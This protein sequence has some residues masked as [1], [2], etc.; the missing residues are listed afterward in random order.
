MG[1]ISMPTSSEHHAPSISKYHVSRPACISIHVPLMLLLLPM[2]V[3][4][5]TAGGG[6]TAHCP[7]CQIEPDFPPN[8][9]ILAA[10]AAARVARL[11][12][13]L[14]PSWQTHCPPRARVPHHWCCSEDQQ[15]HTRIRFTVLSFAGV[16]LFITACRVQF[17]VKTLNWLIRI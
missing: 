2:C 6:D 4:M 17:A 3:I 7:G 1:N 13:K 11:G 15:C 14:G 12:G 9:A 16:L 5:R 10:E 8:L